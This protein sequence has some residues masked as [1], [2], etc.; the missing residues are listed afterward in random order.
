M[1]GAFCTTSNFRLAA[2]VPTWGNPN[3]HKSSGFHGKVSD[4]E[5][6]YPTLEE[7]SRGGERGGTN[8]L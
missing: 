8:K 4:L 5:P 6:F 2:T 3:I 7:G 1:T